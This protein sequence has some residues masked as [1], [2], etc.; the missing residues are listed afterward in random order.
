MRGCSAFRVVFIGLGALAPHA[1]AADSDP[2][3]VHVGKSSLRVSDVERAIA[4]VPDFQLRTLGDTPS[5]IRRNFLD[6]ALIPEVLYDEE[7][8]ERRA[9]DHTWMIGEMREARRRAFIE[10]LRNQ[11]TKESP[12]TEG[13]IAKYYQENVVQFQ[14]EPRL[15]LFRILVR[16]RAEALQILAA[17]RGVGGFD[18][19]SALA[20]D[21][22]LD[23]ATR[24]RA[25]ELGFVRPDGSTDIPQ[26]HVDPA[27]YAAAA[28]VRDGELVAEPVAEQ[29]RF[30]I[31][32]RRGSLPAISRTMDD[33]RTTIVQ[34]LERERLR[35]ALAQLVERL[36][37]ER[38]KDVDAGLLEQMPASTGSAAT[39]AP[40]HAPSAPRAST[41]SAPVRTERGLR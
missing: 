22:S 30:A 27:L 38:V 11:L 17:V 39:P 10:H 23:S 14:S 12:I 29:E 6:A 16:D 13:D 20:R 41:S 31:V 35:T 28:R 36:R 1:L 25:G 4:K 40:A 37:R 24:L 32:W 26:V 18:K 7:A 8:R 34:V 2:A 19:W 5:A 33:E 21:R 15:R 9:R 3:V